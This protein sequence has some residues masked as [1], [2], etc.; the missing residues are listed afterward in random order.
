MLWAIRILFGY[1]I[2]KLS[3]NVLLVILEFIILLL[4]RQEEVLDLDRILIAL[5]KT[6][7][8]IFGD[9][10]GRELFAVF[11]HDERPVRVIYT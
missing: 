1:I 6:V 8:D 9:Y 10:R 4:A 3:L 2:W 7:S 5:L 11:L